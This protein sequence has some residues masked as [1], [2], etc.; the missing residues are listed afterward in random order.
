MEQLVRFCL[1]ALSACLGLY[2]ALCI[3]QKASLHANSGK[4][5]ASSYTVPFNAPL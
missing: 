2:M 1:G 5:N 4:R 3:F